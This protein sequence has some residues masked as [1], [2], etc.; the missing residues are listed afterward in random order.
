MKP[1]TSSSVACERC[2]D[3]RATLV[4]LNA[5]H[6]FRW[7]APRC[8]TPPI[9]Y[10]AATVRFHDLLITPFHVLPTGR[11]DNL[12]HNLRLPRLRASER[13]TPALACIHARSFLKVRPR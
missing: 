8:N 5:L 3:S 1:K 4:S 11:T 2:P 10:R 9:P 13:N 6:R 12:P 7:L